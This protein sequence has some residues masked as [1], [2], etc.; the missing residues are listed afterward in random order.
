M[1][2]VHAWIVI[3]VVAAAV[4]LIGIAIFFLC[5]RG[6]RGKE[7]H[8]ADGG[9]AGAQNHDVA[10]EDQTTE[11]TAKAEEEEGEAKTDEA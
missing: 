4:L 6:G 5:R 1:R 10:V 11:E 9:E 3:V 8:R 7:G 2:D